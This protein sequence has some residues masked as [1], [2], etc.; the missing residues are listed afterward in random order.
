MK[1]LELLH[2]TSNEKKQGLVNIDDWKFTHADHL[3]NMGFE[4]DGDYVMSLKSPNVRVYKKKT[5][6]SEYF[7]VEAENLGTK[8]FRTFEEVIN[9]FDHFPQPEIDKEKE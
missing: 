3:R 8:P 4:F 5:N 7:M 6:G 2:T 1:L 9:Y